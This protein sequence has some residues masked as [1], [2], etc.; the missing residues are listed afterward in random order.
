[1]SQVVPQ[2]DGFGEVLVQTKGPRDAAGDAGHLEGMGQ[3]GAVVVALRGDEDL[4]LVLEPA[5]RLAVHDA[6]SVALVGSA[7]RARLLGALAPPGVRRTLRPPGEARLQLVGGQSHSPGLLVVHSVT[8]LVDAALSDTQ[9]PRHGGLCQ[10]AGAARRPP[11]TLVAPP[12]SP[13][14]PAAFSS[15]TA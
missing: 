13:T 5:E 7:Q 14:L 9:A 2:R 15:S 6:V 1:M 11:Q 3:P 10:A 8:G 12:Q 4:G